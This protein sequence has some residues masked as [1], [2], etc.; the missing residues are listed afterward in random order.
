MANSHHSALLPRF[1]SSVELPGIPVALF[2]LIL[3]GL[4]LVLG[5]R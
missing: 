1:G 5:I 4:L 2:S 3:L